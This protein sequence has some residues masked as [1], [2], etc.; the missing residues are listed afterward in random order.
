MSELDFIELKHI[1]VEENG[2]QIS[3]SAGDYA[4]VKAEH[5]RQFGYMNLTEKEVLNSVRRVI[6]NEKLTDVI[7]HFVK[8]DIVKN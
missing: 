6:N 7:D 8:Q 3:V 4:K 2:K 1:L 5:L